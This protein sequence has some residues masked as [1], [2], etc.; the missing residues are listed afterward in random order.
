MEI[1]V[2]LIVTLQHCWEALIAFA[3]MAVLLLL[4]LT[5]SGGQK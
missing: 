1:Q 5:L 2:P 4:T 3:P